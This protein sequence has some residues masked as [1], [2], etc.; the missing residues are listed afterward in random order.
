MAYVVAVYDV[1]AR[2]VARVMKIFRR[3]L[4]HIQHSVFEGELSSAQ[5][6]RLEDELRNVID[7]TYDHIFFSAWTDPRYLRRSAL[8]ADTTAGRIL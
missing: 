4:N 5:R 8:G 6:R 2:R 1:H 3:Y 7:R